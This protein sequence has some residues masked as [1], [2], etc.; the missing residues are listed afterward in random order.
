LEIKIEEDWHPVV[1]ATHPEGESA[2]NWRSIVSSYPDED[3]QKVTS[4]GTLSLRGI[5]TK[6]SVF[7][8]I[9]EWRHV[10]PFRKPSPRKEIREKYQLRSNSE[11]LASVLHTLSNNRPIA[12]ERIEQKYVEIMEGVEGITTP[13][14][15]STGTAKT[16]VEV[17]E[18]DARYNLSEISAGSKEILSLLTEI[19][20][21]G[22][23]VPIFMIEEPETHLHPDAQR[24]LLDAIR[25]VS[26]ESSTQVLVTTHSDVFVNEV[27]PEGLIRAERTPSGSE[28]RR[29]DPD[30]ISAELSDLGYER[31]G[32]LQ[33]RAVVFVEGRSDKQVL[34][35]FAETVGETLIDQ[36]IHIID[37]EGEGNMH[38]DGQSLVKLLTEFD[39]PYLFIL[40]SHGS[41]PVKKKNELL[42]SVN[43]PRGNWNITPDDVFIWEGYGIESYLL[44]AEAIASLLNTNEKEVSRIINKSQA[45]SSPAESLNRVFQKIAD[46]EYSKATDAQLI[47]R[48][49]PTNSIPEEV[50][51]AI[52]KSQAL[53]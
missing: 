7:N 21:V 31:S 45:D 24:V 32:L 20:I 35:S 28:Y 33:A 14:E 15:T 25:D 11:D 10:S 43:A 12:Y 27:D 19:E 23:E 34:T 22:G 5:L 30:E 3:L 29:I 8:G 4:G 26:K 36:G 17:V 6:F 51:A 1:L 52:E 48:N 39:I 49:I 41:D 38:A 13:I 18:S 40:D 47:A 37:L 16:T 42:D 53:V 46:R 2:K 9:T 50:L 44:N